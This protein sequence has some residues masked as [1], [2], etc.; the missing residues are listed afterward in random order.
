[1]STTTS[2]TS[3]TGVTSNTSVAS[4]D[5][6]IH[7]AVVTPAAIPGG[8]AKVAVGTYQRA[9]VASLQVLSG[10]IVTGMTG[11]AAFATPNPSLADFTAARNDYIAAVNAAK[12]NTI[13]VAVRV[14]KRA[15]LLALIRKLAHYV[16]VTSAGDLP[17]L[18]SSGFTPQL[19]RQPV[20]VLPA[21]QNLRLLRGKVTGQII[22]RT[23]R[24]A[25]AGAYEWRYTTTANPTGWIR[26]DATLSANTTL[27][28]LVPGTQ[29]IVQVRAVGSAGPSDWSDGAMLMAA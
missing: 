8:K 16:Q 27:Y 12:G 21:P 2:G 11:N 26:G 1:M 17:T 25:K 20:G 23:K 28:D 14:Q 7:P 22:A 24:Y 18:L 6:S 9:T 19:T 13:G 29:Y 15:A 5:G 4:N 3:G 10:Y